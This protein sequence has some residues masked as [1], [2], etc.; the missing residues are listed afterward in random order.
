M[1]ASMCLR[2]LSLGYL[3]MAWY[4]KPVDVDNIEEFENKTL[5]KTSLLDR[6]PGSTI[7]C[8]F[9]HILL[10]DTQLVIIHINGQKFWK[11][12]HLKNLKKMEFLI[13]KQ[14]VHLEK[15]YF[16]KVI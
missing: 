4:S 11:L 15:I 8:N 1:S 3:D 9:G 5:E 14:Q 16:L 10:E 6:I 7:S 2:Q 12:M 13:E